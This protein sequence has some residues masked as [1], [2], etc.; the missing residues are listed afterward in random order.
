MC[1]PIGRMGK[2]N[3]EDP[4]TDKQR[5]FVEEYVKD[6]NGTA[7]YKR[8]GY[9]ARTYAAAAAGATALLKNPKISPLINEA[10]ED[11]K[12]R[13]CITQDYVLTTLREIV[14]RCMQRE[15]VINPATGEQDTDE[16]GSPLWK[17]DP[18]GANQALLILAKHVGVAA[19]QIANLNVDMN[20]LNTSQVERLAAGENL[21]AV[22]ASP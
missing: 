6:Y 8:A 18:K 21:L 11:R 12:R 2:A 19:D 4:L 10:I 16:N 22:L 7:A 1:Y 3:V 5:A 15:P 17:F 20:K 9:D 13:N 14:D